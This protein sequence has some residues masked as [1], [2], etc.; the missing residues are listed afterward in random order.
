VF[1]DYCDTP[2][3]PKK[4]KL[5]RSIAKHKSFSSFRIIKKFELFS[6]YFFPQEMSGM[7]AKE[8]SWKKN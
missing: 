2:K 3:K 5:K 4:R 7:T 1:S 6:R 8:E